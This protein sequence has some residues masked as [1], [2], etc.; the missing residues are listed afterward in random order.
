MSNEE[1]KELAAV[2]DGIAHG[3]K[4]QYLGDS[5]LAVRE[6]FDAEGGDNPLVLAC[7]D[8]RKIRLKPDEFEPFRQALREG[9]TVET[10]S[11]AN[12]WLKWLGGED[13]GSRKVENFRIK[14][15]PQIVPLGPEDVP[16]GSVFQGRNEFA[17]EYYTP[18]YVGLSVV[19]F[20]DGANFSLN[21]TQLVE[22]EWKIK[23]PGEDWK[24]CYKEVQP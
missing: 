2:L 22:R 16:P 10:L 11:I 13:F 6:W 17:A 12:G 3:K 23:R 20:R 19:E 4:W 7:N 9:K 8:R 14:P 18:C 15:E 24:P 21:Y 5:H 1:L